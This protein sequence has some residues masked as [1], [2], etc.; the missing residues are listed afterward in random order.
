M[1]KEALLHLKIEPLR[2]ELL[3]QAKEKWDSIAKPLDGFGRF[4]TM[5]ARIGAIKGTVEFSI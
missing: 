3:L 5:L 4:E 1:T 2:Q